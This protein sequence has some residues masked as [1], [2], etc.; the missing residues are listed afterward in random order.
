MT[1]A[2]P[3]RLNAFRRDRAA[4]T[5]VEFAF[6][7]P[8]L[9]LL[10]LGGA[11]L[12]RYVVATE[13][14]EQAANTI[15]QMITENSSGAV[16]YIDLQ[17]YH[18]SAMVTFPDVLSDAATQGVAW[19][20][21]ISITMS[22]VSFAPTPA[23]CTSNCTYVPTMVWSAGDNRRSCTVKMTQTIDA[24]VPT[25]TTLPVDIYG[26]GS[27]IVVDLQYN[28]HPFFAPSFIGTINIA[29]SV[30]MAPR[31]VSLISYQAISG[32]NGIATSC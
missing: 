15:G 30:Y 31:Y 16:N 23:T 20:S 9:V 7:A 14:I 11:D 8:V 24:S 19:W 29:R 18:D 5:A 1:P 2:F 28:F 27:A 6:V 10:A 17:F 22:S 25:A 13:R 12:T 4:A 26:P 21:D 32:D 3:P